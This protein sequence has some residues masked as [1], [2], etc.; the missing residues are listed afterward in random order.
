[1]S[2]ARRGCTVRVGRLAVDGRHLPGFFARREP[3]LDARVRGQG[4]DDRRHH[5]EVHRRPAVHEDAA[6]ARRRLIRA[7]YPPDGAQGRGRDRH[8]A[9]ASAVVTAWA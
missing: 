4:A 3:E 6:P 2:A 9:R 8:H 1:M 5:R 7:S